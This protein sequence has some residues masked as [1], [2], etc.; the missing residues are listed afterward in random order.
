MTDNWRLWLPLVALILLCAGL[1][2]MAQRLQNRSLRFNK[3]LKLKASLVLGPRERIAIVEVAGQCILVGITPNQITNLLTF[4]SDQ[5]D[6]NNSIE[7]I[8]PQVLT[9]TTSWLKRHQPNHS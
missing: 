2:W 6:E 7:Q 8:H 3:N 9:K 1:A 5:L 4:S